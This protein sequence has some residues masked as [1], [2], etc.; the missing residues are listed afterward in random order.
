MKLPECTFDKY[1][2]VVTGM[3]YIIDSSGTSKVVQ[4]HEDIFTANNIGYVVIFPISR[5]SGEGISWHVKTTGCYAFVINGQFVSVMTALEVLNTLSRLQMQ[6]KTCIGILIHHIFRTDI[7]EVQWMLDKI[8]MV[9]VIYYLHDFYTCCIN[10]NMLKN[11]KESCV[12]GG[13]CCEGCVYYIK[14]HSHLNLI[15]NFLVSFGERLS[16]V[17]PS[18]YV[19]E[20]WI[21]YHSEFASKVRVIAHQRSIGQYLNNKEEIPANEPISIGFVGAQT[22]IK[23]W[24]VFKRTIKKLQEADCNYSYFYFGHGKEQL[25]GVTNVPVEIAMMGKDAMIKAIRGK[26]ISVVFLMCLCGETYSYTMY[27]SHAANSYILTMSTSGNIAYTVNRK[28]WGSVLGTEEE[29]FL[30]LHDE[31]T[32]RKTLNNWR[33]NSEPGAF[34]YEDNDEVLELF[35]DENVGEIVWKTRHSSLPKL[36]KRIILNKIFIAT[37]LMSGK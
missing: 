37:R 30:K 11:D 28:S 19:K 12:D 9:P 25:P 32:F 34:E 17:A 16:F 33:L 24:D 2:F 23:G 35:H 10:P 15:N 20:R 18:E 31:K 27:E 21:T 29:I 8:Q 14:R 6:G 4:A 7:F 26:S 22:H 36:L 1:I 3:S 13:V 5:S